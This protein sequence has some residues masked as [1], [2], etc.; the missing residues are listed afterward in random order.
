MLTCKNI[1]FKLSESLDIKLPF[2]ERVLINMHLLMCTRCKKFSRQ[3]KIMH[4]ITQYYVSQ[5]ENSDK[6]VKEELSDEAR[7]R[8][9]KK[10]IEYRQQ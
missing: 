5:I 2:G 9:Y 3:I 8:I 7:Q 6:R 10:L 4:N 1:T